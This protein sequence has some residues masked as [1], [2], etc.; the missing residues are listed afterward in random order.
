MKNN[1]I[2]L[3]LASI[4]FIFPLRFATESQPGIVW[5]FSMIACVLGYAALLFI[6]ISKPFASKKIVQPKVKVAEHEM[7]KKK[8]AVI[9]NNTC[10]VNLAE[11]I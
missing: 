9:E 6:F 3:C 11:A 5:L 2:G 10:S 4:L 7:E 8:L 1:L